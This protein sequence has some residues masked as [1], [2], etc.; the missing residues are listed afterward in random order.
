MKPK[1][2]IF[3]IF[4]FLILIFT[5]SCIYKTDEVVTQSNDAKNLLASCNNI[6]DE[7]EKVI[8]INGIALAFKDVNI[9]NNLVG[10]Y[11]KECYV[12]VAAIKQDV[13]ICNSIQDSEF[14]DV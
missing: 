12:S 14:K 1:Y 2:Q 9:C 6:N 10:D 7:I 3:L 8:C 11:G 5:V 4:L 13:T